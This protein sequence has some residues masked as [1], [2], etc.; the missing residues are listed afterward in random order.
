V[1]LS[2]LGEHTVSGRQLRER[3]K[4]IGLKRSGP[5]FYQLMARLEERGYVQGWYKQAVIDGQIIKQRFY[6][7]TSEG[8][9][10]LQHTQRFYGVQ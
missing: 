1:I 9:R 2:L 8:F 4:D 5:A 3:L 6:N 10:V 7:V